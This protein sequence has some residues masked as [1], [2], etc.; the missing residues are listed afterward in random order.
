[1]KLNQLSQNFS[2][3]TSL[4]ISIGVGLL[5]I[6]GGIGAYFA[7][8]NKRLPEGSPVGANVIPQEAMI[9]IA[10]TT[11]PTEWEKLRRLGTT[12][13]RLAFDRF[14]GELRDKILT[15]N[16]YGYQQDIQPWI[17][18]QMMI[19]FLQNKTPVPISPSTP[20]A[21]QSIVMVLPVANPT[22]A[23]EVLSLS[24]SLKDPKISQRN[25]KGVSIREMRE[26]TQKNYSLALLGRDYLLVTTDPQATNRAIDTYKGGDS[27]L[28]TPGYLE[29][30]KR[31]KMPSQFAQIYVNIPVASSFTSQTS[32]R[33]LPEE[34]LEKLEQTQGFVSNITLESTGIRLTSI[35]WLKPN[36]EKKLLVENNAGKML[37]LLPNTTVAMLGGGNFQQ[38]WKGYIEG[39]NRN[40]LAPLKPEELRLNIKNLTGMDWDKD[41][42]SWMGGEFSFALIPAISGSTNPFG[43]GL[44][45]MV[46]TSDKKAAD[47]T[48]KQLDT[49]MKTKQFKVEEIQVKNVPV[50]QWT[51]PFGGVTVNYGWLNNRILFWNL[52]APVLESILPT[53]PKSLKT[54]TLFQK[55]VSLNL[56]PHTGNFFIDVNNTLNPKTL[57]LP[58]FPPPQKLWLNSIQSIGNTVAIVDERTTMYDTFVLFNSTP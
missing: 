2:K 52:G 56:T 39:A 15:G 36:S 33:P 26:S 57:S 48:L 43:A 41:W 19:A 4:F 32:I 20:P 53:P 14:L 55:T 1:M 30:L 35:S 25:Y 50:I 46:E 22:K 16:G 13:S 34:N 44:V 21:Q 27:L 58:E 54:N 12:D 10:V 23:Q 28:K 51:S 38:L 7:L 37:T 29:Q 45:F 42:V 24:Q 11:N 6:G 18:N 17:G 3:K 8:T 5:L 47:K 40:P 31:I 9:A 49:V